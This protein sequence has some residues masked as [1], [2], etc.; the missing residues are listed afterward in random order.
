MHINAFDP[1]FD[2]AHQKPEKE[3]RASSKK[4]PPHRLCGNGTG[5]NP[6]SFCIFRGLHFAIYIFCILR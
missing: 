4:I 2:F 6:V 1:Y 3:G 5:K